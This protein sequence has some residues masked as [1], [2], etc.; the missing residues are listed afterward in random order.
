VFLNSYLPYLNIGNIYIFNFIALFKD[1]LTI[2]SL[3][4]SA[5]LLTRYIA[6]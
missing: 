1:N 3:I 5:L 6:L 4:K 2:F